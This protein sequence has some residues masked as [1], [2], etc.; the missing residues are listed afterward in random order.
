MRDSE[1]T[2]PESG[3]ETLGQ[4]GAPRKWWG[5]ADGQVGT[6]TSG[7]RV[8]QHWETAGDGGICLSLLL[9]SAVVRHWCP[10]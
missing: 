9:G 8:G 4:R 3:H 1:L 2:G 7:Q 6:K 5:S 10:L